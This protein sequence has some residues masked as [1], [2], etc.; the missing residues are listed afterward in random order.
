MNHER[1][2]FILQKNDTLHW[3][4][5]YVTGQGKMQTIR[6]METNHILKSNTNSKNNTF[7]GSQKIVTYIIYPK[8]NVTTDKK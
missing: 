4:L 6:T 3:F 8:Q 5:E 1:K 2:N 7:G